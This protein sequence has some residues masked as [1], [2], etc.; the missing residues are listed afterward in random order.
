V[1]KEFY[2]KAMPDDGVYCVAYNTPNTPSFVH[3]YTT[4]IDEAV[5]LIHKYTKESKN[6]F[7]AMS[8]FESKERKAANTKYVKSLYIDLDVGKTKD[9]PSQKDALVAL[10]KFIED[11]QLPFPAVVNSGNGIHAYW[12]LK[13]QIPRDQWKPIADRFKSLCIQE[14]LRIDP[15]VTAD[16]ARL[17]RCP[18]TNNYKQDPPRPTLILKDAPEY[19]LSVIVDIINEK[20]TEE[21]PLEELVKTGLTDEQ[22]KEKYKNFE[23]RFKPFLI[24]SV[25]GGEKGCAQVK[26]Y[27]EN[28]KTSEEPVWWRVLSLAQNCVDRDDVIH[29]ISKDHPGYTREE[30]EEK[31]LS[32]EGKPHTCVDFNS[33]KADLCTACPHWQKITSPIQLTKVPKKLEMAEKPPVLQG[34]V[35]PKVTKKPHGLPASMDERG[36]WIG[37]S[38]HAVYKTITVTDKK[39]VS[40]ND[41]QVVYEYEMIAI[42]HV[43]SSVDGT[44]LVVHVKHPHDGLLEFIL[45]MKVVYDPTELR[46]TLTSN[47]LYYDSKQQE[48]LIMRYFIDWAKDMQKRSKYD[49]MYDQMG[50]NEDK[51]SFVIGNTELS[52]DGTE[53][54]TPISHLARSVAPFLSKSGT[55]ED[56][57]IA[58]QKLNQNGL[59]MHM[60]TT[61]CG[62]GSILMDYSSTTGVAISLTGESG[63]AKTGALYAALSIWGKPKD[64]A[65]MNTTSNALQ[66]RFLTLHNIPF[67]FDEVGNKNPYLISDFILSV[68]QGKAKLKM[69]GSTNSEREYEAPASLIAIM[70]SNHSL[71]DKLK[72]IRS[73]P[74]GEAARLIEFPVRKPKSFIDN[75]RLGKEIFDEFNSHYGWAGPLF[76]RAVFEYGTEK[77]IKNNLIKWE[78]RFVEDFGNDTAYRFYENLIAVTMTAAEIVN[79]ADILT[80]D[81]ER[82]YNFIVGEMI[83]IRDQVGKINSV[84]YESVLQDY[85]DANTDKILAFQDGKIINEPYRALTMRVD[86]DKDTMWISKKEFDSYLAELPISTKEFVFQMKLLNI[87]IE[88]GSHVKQRM[89]AGWKDVSKSA[90]AVYKIKL[91]TLGV[92]KI[93]GLKNAIA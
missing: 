56:W 44:C 93:A 28:V 64:L 30:T 53:K 21:V 22:I 90:T 60:F 15:T 75:A 54:T 32:T 92:E 77:D 83:T 49:V 37:K 11:T 85:I 71:Y 74:N 35:L 76:V 65:V 67:G 19:N 18:E 78:N 16:S 48:E 42:R 12:F 91:S 33:A 82:I 2:T 23:N 29:T 66:G 55:Y 84:D 36:Y 50:W 62:F 43:K 73:N 34:E 10:T 38:D 52:R 9:Y 14:G 58:A 17:L 80:I 39:G 72:T 31:A 7:I 25:K 46:K 69:Q 41:D 87:E 61:L 1:L 81:V 68:S 57:Q 51:S 89:N 88:V 63:A 24:E 27:V 86:N 40:Y 45:P 8:T 26:D 6:T 5:D 70:T 79:K 47:G 4:S 3:E 20:V 59:E 13:T